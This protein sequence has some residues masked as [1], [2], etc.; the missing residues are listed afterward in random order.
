MLYLYE[1]LGKTELQGSLGQEQTEAAKP[2]PGTPGSAIF[3]PHFWTLSSVLTHST[4]VFV[5]PVWQII[6]FFL[7][8]LNVTHHDWSSPP[9]TAMFKV[10]ILISEAFSK[11]CL[12]DSTISLLLS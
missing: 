11:K 12:C 5:L 7:F 9:N 4:S 2:I 1:I 3:L 10:P 8:S 6:W